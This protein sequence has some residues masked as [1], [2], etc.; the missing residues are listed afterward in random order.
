MSQM[1][2][3]RLP[4]MKRI[5]SEYRITVYAHTNEHDTFLPQG[6]RILGVQYYSGDSISIWALV[7]EG[8]PL[9]T[10]RC[11]IYGTGEP[12]S[13]PIG[14]YLGTVDMKGVI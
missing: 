9:E 1:K 4:E 14:G 13:A 5:I 10:R 7:D 3:E 2:I 6:A 11:K 8:M 12:L